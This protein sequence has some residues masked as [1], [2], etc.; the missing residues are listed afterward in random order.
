MAIRN[1]GGTGEILDPLLTVYEA[2][3]SITV[4]SRP[5]LLSLHS[6]AKRPAGY[7]P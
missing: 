7:L 4:H 2:V 6:L 1:A 5:R 3:G